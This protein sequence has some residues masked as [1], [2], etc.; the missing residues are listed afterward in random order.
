[1]FSNGSLTTDAYSFAATPPNVARL[2]A[3][4]ALVAA[5]AAGG[6]AVAVRAARR[7]WPRSGRG[8]NPVPAEGKREK[9]SSSSR[10]RT[11]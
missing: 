10:L 8:D 6:L 1:M 9:S 4:W 5:L 11:A 3:D 7:H 2:I